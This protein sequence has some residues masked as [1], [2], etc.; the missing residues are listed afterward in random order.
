MSAA[1]CL[2]ASEEELSA[3]IA[4]GDSGAFAEL[5]ERFAPSLLGRVTEREP[6]PRMA[7]SIVFNVFLEFWRQAPRI[8]SRSENVA[9]WLFE[10]AT[11]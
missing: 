5:Y 7:E 9:A 1:P 8:K 10:K 4:L 6:D 11:V 3:A 2:A